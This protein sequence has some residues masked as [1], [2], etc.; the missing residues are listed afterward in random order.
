MKVFTVGQEESYDRGIEEF[1]AAF[2]KKGRHEGYAGGF[3]FASSA[4]A[5]LLIEEM[6]MKGWAVYELD[7]D[8]VRDTVPIEGGWW[9]ELLVDSLILRKVTEYDAT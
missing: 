4:D 9:R 8:L 7:A 6:G 5:S 3:A 1:G 2:Q